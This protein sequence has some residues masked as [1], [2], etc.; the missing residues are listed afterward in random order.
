MAPR[1]LKLFLTVGVMLAVATTR[2]SAE[3]ARVEGPLAPLAT[4][5]GFSQSQMDL[6]LHEINTIVSD[7][8]SITGAVKGQCTSGPKCA[9]QAY[10]NLHWLLH[11]HRILPVDITWQRG[12]A[13]RQYIHNFLENNAVPH[14]ISSNVIGRCLEWDVRPGSYS[15]NAACQV[16]DGITYTEQHNQFGTSLAA[17]GVKSGTQFLG[18]IHN[19]SSTFP[20]LVFEHL[21]DPFQAAREIFT[22]VRPGGKVIVTA[23]HISPEHGVPYDFFRYTR[24]GLMTVFM[25]AGFTVDTIEKAG[26]VANAVAMLEGMDVHVSHLLLVTNKSGDD[27]G[28]PYGNYLHLNMI[29]SKPM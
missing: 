8:S 19:F 28:T 13:A 7:P 25:K 2:I 18:D 27:K 21:H 26:N 29:V 23:P 14:L 6:F 20:E 24:M 3:D 22:I 17:K 4:A 1:S 11:Q 9:K 12:A 10:M 5:F 16:T 15:S